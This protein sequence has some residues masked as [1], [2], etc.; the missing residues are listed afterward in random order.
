MIDKN[1][2]LV[3]IDLELVY[4]V[5][6]RRP[7]PPF[8]WGTPGFMSPEQMKACTPTIA[9]DIFGLGALMMTL[10]TG[11]SPDKLEITEPGVIFKHIS[12]YEMRLPIYDVM[13]DCLVE[14]P[15]IRPELKTIRQA[16]MEY[17]LT[18]MDQS[19]HPIPY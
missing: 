19:I 8:K 1:G 15:M 6:M 3:L 17:R 5:A 4:S 10:M 14:N 12:F 11:V 16:V 7:S 18:L 9:E 13:M 2:R